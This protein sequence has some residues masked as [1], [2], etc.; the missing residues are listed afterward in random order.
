MDTI[1]NI[2]HAICKKAK[3]KSK[4]W[5]ICTKAGEDFRYDHIFFY[6][7]TN[8]WYTVESVCMNL[9]NLIKN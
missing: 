2:R 1:R 4:D 5:V 7:G 6:Q 9:Y 8:I 3:T